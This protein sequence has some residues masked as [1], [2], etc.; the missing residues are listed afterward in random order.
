MKKNIL[1]FSVAVVLF[2]ASCSSSYNLAENNTK[3]LSVGSSAYTLPTVAELNVSA[4]KIS[5]QM[6]Y[7]NNLSLKDISKFSDSPKVQ[8]MIKLTMN[9]AAEKYEA[10]VI[11]A[12]NYTIA[13]SEDFKNVTITVT[14]Y[15]ATYT[16]FHTA[17]ATE[18]NLIKGGEGSTVIPCSA[19]SI[20][21]RG[22]NEF[23]AR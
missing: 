4:T 15:P 3:L 19:A 9:K 18:M 13:T 22:W 21:D 7:Q 8:Y 1:F 14:G 20:N 16:N 17:T 10:D 2:L 12:P 23:Y 5:F 11:V 6:T